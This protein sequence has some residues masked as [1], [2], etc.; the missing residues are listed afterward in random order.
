MIDT[1]TRERTDHELLRLLNIRPNEAMTPFIRKKVLETSRLEGGNG[2]D[3]PAVMSST[4][5]SSA[6]SR[7]FSTTFLLTA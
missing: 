3:W 2:Y 6:A 5:S 4:P 7:S 1:R